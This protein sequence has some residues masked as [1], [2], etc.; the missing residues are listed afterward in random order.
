MI[1]LITVTEDN[2]LDVASLSVKESQRTY[3]AP[4]IGILARGYVYRDCNAKVYAVEND[5]VIVGTALVREFTDEPLGY[6]LQQFMI[7]QKYQ[8]KGFGSQAL[9]MIL[10]DLRQENHYDHVELCV[11]KEDA[12]AI[13]LYEK[14]GF[15]D[16]GYIDAGLPDSLNMICNL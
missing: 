8:R 15:V 13:H 16:S 3:V 10:E 7:D 12:E 2:W 1:R 6:D 9:K 5:G 14:L 11:K 4:A